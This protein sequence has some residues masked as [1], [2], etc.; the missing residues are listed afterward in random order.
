MN[1][2]CFFC[3][4]TTCS[5]TIREFAHHHQLHHT[6]QCLPPDAL[7]TEDSP[8]EVSEPTLSF[9]HFIFVATKT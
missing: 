8:P 3:I 7:S 2:S 5:S 1:L 6:L 4:A 9:T